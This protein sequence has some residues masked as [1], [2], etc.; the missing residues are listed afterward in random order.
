MPRRPGGGG[1]LP[2]SLEAGLRELALN[3]GP[4]VRALSRADTPGLRAIMDAAQPPAN[5]PND[6]KAS[7]VLQLIKEKIRDL[8]NPRW[9]AAAEAA[10]RI[11]ED[12]FAGPGSDSLA[13]RFRA[14]ARV[15]GEVEPE[16]LESRASA[17]RGY[18]INAA[19]HLASELQ[20][21]LDQCN[22]SSDR[23]N[24]YRTIEPPAPLRSLPI[25]FDRSDVLFRFD[26][27][28]GTQ[29]ISYRWL[30]AHEPIDYY[31]AVG[32]YYNE[33]A[34]PVEIVPL[35]NCELDGP[36]LELP[37]GGICQR[38]KFSTVLAP[39]QQYFFAYTT[40]FNSDQPSWPTILY[41]V[42]G[43]GMRSLTVRAQFDRSYIPRKLW[44]LDVG[45]E[46][47]GYMIPD[48]SSDD[49]IGISNNGYVEHHFPHCELG[50][51]Y[52]L[53]WLWN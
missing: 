8:R 13:G 46:S 44:C 7:A 2:N 14:V 40:V 24:F 23:W 43:R 31:D 35:A 9:R 21:A 28:R 33:P 27:M 25:S 22:N 34:A 4:D 53:R 5:W 51:K 39:G 36:P 6:A 30:T 50:R 38:L 12:R 47:E 19:H 48:D 52:G 32:H 10:F 3:H 16:H 41:E 26:G 37:A 29:S 11:P 49:V 17:Y 45:I 15:Q 20:H 18:W 42:R 1:A